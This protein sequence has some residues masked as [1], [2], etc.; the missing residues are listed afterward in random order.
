MSVVPQHVAPPAT[1][2]LR[3]T[4]L[5]M[6]LVTALILAFEISVTRVCSV[7]LQY[8]MIFAVVSFAV[9]GLGLGGFAAS[10]WARQDEGRLRPLSTVATWM[11]A[12]AMLLTLFTLVLAPFAAYWTVLL[13]VVLPPFVA[14]GVFQSIALRVL[15]AH[16]ATLYA[17]DLAGAATGALAAVI[18]LDGLGGPLCV[19]FLLAALA[20]LAAWCWGATGQRPL[21]RG[22]RIGPLL[23]PAMAC[24]AGGLFALQWATS[25]LDVSYERT[26]HKLIASALQPTAEGTPRLVPE[27]Q[28]WDAYS[29]VDVVDLETTR[30]VQRLVFIDGETPTVMLPP[31]SGAPGSGGLTVEKALPALPY[32]LRQR[33]SVLSIG[34]G[35][36]YDV[37]TAKRFGASKVDAVELNAGVLGVVAQARE[38]TGD[39]YRQDGVRLIHGEGRQFVRA[40]AAGSYD[41][42]VML[43]AQSLAGNLREYALSENYLY[44][45]QAFEDY[46]RVLGEAGTLAILV[47]NDVLLRK[48]VRTALEVL[49]DRGVD[50]PN[51]I[52]AFESP[53]E[54]P[55]DRLLVVQTTPFVYQELIALGREVRAGRYRVVHLPPTAAAP[56]PQ[57]TLAALRDD[58]HR[59][60]PATDDRPFFFHVLPG[61][62]RGLT[63]ILLGSAATLLVAC[64]LLLRFASRPER[65]GAV[66]FTTAG[67]FVLLGLGFLMV[68]VIVLQKA[69]LLLSF[70]TLNLA[71]VLASFLLAAGLGSAASAAIELRRRES[72]LRVVLLLLA[73]LVPLI[74]PFLVFV[75][76]TILAES[77]LYRCLAVAAAISPFA[78]LMGIPFPLGISLLRGAAVRW[79]PWLWG[80]NGVAS[81]L[82]SAVVVVLALK[83]GF[84]LTAIVPA[85]CYLLALPLAAG[86]SSEQGAH[87]AY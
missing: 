16:A 35:G 69:I 67:Y 44:T 52:A 49:S 24:V 46:L 20:A 17:A 37:V 78:F 38:F 21:A 81:V 85:A 39:V 57:L 19:I 45:R 10:W 54:H 84:Y 65:R 33:Q 9:L 75:Q 1:W 64:G 80:L 2:H 36:G 4:A 61:V 18:L 26:P 47:N 87:D 48:L 63:V 15:S 82:G 70:P 86:L 13:V 51:C 42:V 12:P 5:M 41:L 32:R 29:R 40:A 59:L 66:G 27:L 7:L 22:R 76:D 73:L 62:P 77:L 60:Q 3:S 68:E 34:S 58:P 50:G 79:V 23:P 8:H 53:L 30:G 55:Y 71:V 72:C 74:V 43:L 6:F 11:L 83:A 14:V 31:D 56:E 28:R 25:F